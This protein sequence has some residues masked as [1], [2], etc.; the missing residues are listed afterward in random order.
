MNYP[1]TDATKMV[2][3]TNTQKIFTLSTIKST[4]IIVAYKVLSIFPCTTQLLY[5]E[6]FAPL[7]C[8]ANLSRSGI[9]LWQTPSVTD[10]LSQ[11]CLIMLVQLA[12]L[13]SGYNH[14][15]F[16]QSLQNH[17]LAYNTVVDNETWGRLRLHAYTLRKKHLNVWIIPN[18][19]HCSVYVGTEHTCSDC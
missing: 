12:S 7:N 4:L 6:K 14:Q 9:I 5:Y 16:T 8:L 15:L 19:R 17:E 11:S 1:S 13:C 18:L 10:I 3:W 2:C